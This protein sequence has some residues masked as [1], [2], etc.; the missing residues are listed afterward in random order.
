MGSAGTLLMLAVAFVHPT[1]PIWREI[2]DSVAYLQMTDSAHGGIG[3]DMAPFT[4][5]WLAPTLAGLL[6]I[7]P[8]RAMQVINLLLL[9]A[10][11][12]ALTALVSAWCRRTSAVAVAIVVYAVAVPVLQFGAGYFVDG[13]AVGAV[14]IGLW[15]M[16]RRP[17]WFALLAVV[18]GVMIKETALILVGVGIAYEL[19]RTERTRQTWTRVAAWVGTGLAAYVV[20]GLIGR[21]G[22][23]VFVPWIPSSLSYLNLLLHVNVGRS[24]MW[25][26]TGATLLVPLAALAI[27]FLG[28]RRGWIRIPRNRLV[29]VG[30]GVV[31]AVLLTVWAIVGAWWDTRSSW[32]VLPFGAALAA[33]VADPILEHGI[34]RTLRDRRV[35]RLIGA[36][37][38]IGVG[39]LVV[40]ALTSRAMRFDGY[41]APR[42]QHR[43]ADAVG[44]KI[45]HH[46]VRVS[47]NGE[48]RLDIP[49]VGDGGPVVMDVEPAHPGNVTVSLDDSTS[50]PLYDGHLDGTGT[51][52]LDSETSPSSVTVSADGDWKV[53]FRSLNTV[54]TFGVLNT[55]RGN[56]PDVVLVPDGSRLSVAAIFAASTPGSHF[57]LVG[58]CRVGSCP[59]ESA[60]KLPIGLE[61]LVV[62]DPGKWS[63][64]PQKVLDQAHAVRIE[65][66][67]AH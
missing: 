42:Q 38:L 30:V 61:A 51:F 17:L 41:Q 67:K 34:M 19:T 66:M 14:A 7:G 12:F 49:A 15:A 37:A 53:R 11:L 24:E 54:S 46:I 59:D 13:A 20:A 35:R 26:Y 18:F 28:D 56:G 21:G 16:Y 65:D 50:K 8:E 45:D 57:Q 63:V 55:L 25:L 3:S 44:G 58:Q 43:F 22:R 5:R 60:G 33:L 39:C 62:D 47:G 31:I 1:S 9:A 52:L 10:G 6:P 40:M 48:R 32:V 29:P 64:S 4:A 36:T 27:G 2:P 23:L